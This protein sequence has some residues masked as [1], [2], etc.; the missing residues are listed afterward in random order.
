MEI[1]FRQKRIF[2]RPFFIDGFTGQKGFPGQKKA[3][4]P[5]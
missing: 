4:R 5:R 1:P 3:G 2:A